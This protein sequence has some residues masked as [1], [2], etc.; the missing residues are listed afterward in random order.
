MNKKIL[1]LVLIFV[2]AIIVTA[3][4]LPRNN[5]A[6]TSSSLNIPKEELADNS[7]DNPLVGSI[8]KTNPF[9]VDI[10]PMRGYKNPFSK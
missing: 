6:Q 8:T 2:L 7:A 10:N 3:Y 1:I 4:Y 5:Q 9:N